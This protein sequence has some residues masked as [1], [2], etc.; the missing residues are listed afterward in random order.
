MNVEFLSYKT[1][2]KGIYLVRNPLPPPC[3]R[4]RETEAQGEVLCA[5]EALPN[6]GRQQPTP[7]FL[8][9]PIGGLQPC[10]LA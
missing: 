1:M 4:S 7:A 6:W 8:G 2:S 9:D 10:H 5:C 3:L